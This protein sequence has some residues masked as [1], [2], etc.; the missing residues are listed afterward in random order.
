VTA[1]P[2]RT[3]HKLPDAVRPRRAIALVEATLA[4][5][6]VAIAVGAGLQAAAAS[7][8]SRRAVLDQTFA[9]QLAQAMLDEVCA[10][11]YED[12]NQAPLFGLES[13]ETRTTARTTLDDVDDY[14]G[15]SETV[16]RGRDGVALVVPGRYTRRVTVSL[17]RPEPYLASST[18]D[19]GI[20]QV[21]VEVSIGTKVLCRLTALRTRAM[22]IALR[23]REP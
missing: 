18:T 2:R 4:V 15:L 9:R 8:R 3:S 1:M 13:S 17:L 20:K 21:V 23:R 7:A 22:D 16:L 14:A 11:P 6:V 10:Q 19:Q 5:L 12:Q